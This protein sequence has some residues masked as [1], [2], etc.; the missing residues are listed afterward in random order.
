VARRAIPTRK[1]KREHD[2]IIVRW[3]NKVNWERRV[4]AVC[5]PCWE[6]KYC[7]YG[8]LVEQF[9]LRHQSEM[10]CRIFGHDCPV[11]YVAEPL[12]ETKEPR[13]ISRTIPRSVQFRVLKR[14]NQICSVCGS[15]VQ[16]KDVEFDHIIPWSKGGSSDESNVRLLCRPCNRKRRAEFEKEFLVAGAGEHLIE[17]VD[18]FVVVWLTVVVDFGLSF[19]RSHGKAPTARDYAKEFGRKETP[20][21]EE[22]EAWTFGAIKEFFSGKRPDD[23]PQ[24]VFEALRLR[25]GFT[26]GELHLL[27]AAA[28]A[29][30]NSIDDLLAGERDLLRRLGWVVKTTTEVERKWRS[31]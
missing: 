4:K 24:P 25:W 8:P 10:H 12:T 14:E 29:T 2:S 9:P 30:N 17:P 13:N 27:K 23:L 16:D 7:P 19:Q 15:P 31:L 28:E 11:F 18:A 3:G 1:K 26:D 22:R 21:L 20:G 6:L 5:K